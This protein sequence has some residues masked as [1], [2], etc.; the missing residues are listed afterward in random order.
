MIC[1]KLIYISLSDLRSCKV[2]LYREDVVVPPN[3]K[4]VIC[5]WDAVFCAHSIVM[6]MKL[7]F[8]KKK[9]VFRFFP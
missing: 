2:R 7:T 3:L 9:N 1:A 6:D 8:L 4:I 5:C